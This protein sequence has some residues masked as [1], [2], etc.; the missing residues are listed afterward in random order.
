MEPVVTQGRFVVPEVVATHFHLRP[1]DSVVD[2]GAGKGFFL[3]SLSRLVGPTGRVYALEIQKNLVEAISETIRLQ[4]L[5]NCEAIWCD[6]EAVNGSK[7]DSEALD[8]ALLI[9][10]L[11]QIEDKE[12]TLKE[13][14]RVLRA[15][16]KLIVVDWTES[17][18]GLGPQPA[19]VISQHDAQ[20]LLEAHGF[21]LENSFDAG[22]HHY[23][24][25]FRKV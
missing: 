1:G 10:T 7:L 19:D 3:P 5:S 9:N 16:G 4:N 18:A 22:D 21:V 11:F 13:I 2:F 14:H 24:L 17:F 6:I 20:A 25:S 15:G 12:A 23:G 8:V